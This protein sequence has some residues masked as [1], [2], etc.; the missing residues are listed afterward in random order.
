MVSVFRAEVPTISLQFEWGIL[1]FLVLK[2]TR[3]FDILKTNICRMLNGIFIDRG[4]KGRKE[5]R[6]YY[7]QL[8][9]PKFEVPLSLR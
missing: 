7:V 4:L 8:Y 3:G 5:L 6:F 9:H 1:L 2:R